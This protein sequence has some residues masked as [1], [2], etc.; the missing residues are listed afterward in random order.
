MYSYV[1]TYGYTCVYI[2]IS[3]SIYLN[4]SIY[5]HIYIYEY[6]YKYI[7]IYITVYTGCQPVQ[8]MSDLRHAPPG[9]R[10][11]GRT[12]P[13]TPE[14]GREREREGERERKR[15]RENKR[16]RES[17]SRARVNLAAEFKKCTHI[18]PWRQLRGNLMISLVKSHTNATRIGWHLWE[19]DLR[20][21]PGLPPGWK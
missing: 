15:E 13:G 7:Y 11:E 21:A 19:I 20:F 9:T 12:L 5:R 17:K 3:M 10:V 1:Y 16:K 6:I 2:Y 4:L 18:P 8:V 14:R